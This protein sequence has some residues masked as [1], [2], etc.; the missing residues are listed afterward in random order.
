M[1]QCSYCRSETELYAGGLPI[2]LKCSDAPESKLTPTPEQ[3]RRQLVQETVDATTQTD[4]A[5]LVFNEVMDHFPSG[6]P[7]PDGS[8]RIQN[9]SRTLIRARKDLARTNNRLDDYLSSGIVPED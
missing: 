9:A 8:Q 7:H 2:C 4:E 1:A 5:L 3:V 6:L